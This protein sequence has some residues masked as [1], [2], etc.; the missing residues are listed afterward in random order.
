MSIPLPLIPPD[1]LLVAA[2]RRRARS[3][4]KQIAL[5]FRRRGE[6]RSQ[7]WAQFARLVD[8]ITAVWQGLGIGDGATV[9]LVG[10]FSEASLA[11]ALGLTALGGHLLLGRDTTQSESCLSP[12]AFLL[13]GAEDLA[14]LSSFDRSRLVVVRQAEGVVTSGDPRLHALDTL[15]AGRALARES[16][17]KTL[18]RQLFRS[19]AGRGGQPIL[20]VGGLESEQVLHDVLYWWLTQAV[21]LA[22]P[23]PRG[24]AHN[25]RVALQP[26]WVLDTVSGYD[27]WAADINTRWPSAPSWHW[28]ML[29]WTCPRSTV[30][31]TSLTQDEPLANWGLKAWLQA[32][33]RRQLG[34]ARARR[35]WIS[36]APS[37]AATAALSRLGLALS[38]PLEQSLPLSWPASPVV[39]LGD[40]YRVHSGM[41][42]GGLV[43]IKPLRRTG[44]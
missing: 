32:R 9:A 16:S 44:P 17:K 15:L 7:T 1:P 14:G 41:S 11:T 31:R 18:A 4:P 5:C 12:D 20:L 40:E 39:P 22:L 36:G 34:L 8:D 28:R 33:V 37:P 23:E 19:L 43:E 13:D 6:W 27:R 26:D 25:D 42:G 24:D 3:T 38:N 10:P 30:A 21:V 29:E 35:L 2:L